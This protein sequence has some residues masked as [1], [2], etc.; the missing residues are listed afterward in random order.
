MLM[1]AQNEVF[2]EQFRLG[3]IVR[4]EPLMASMVLQ[5]RVQASLS[6]TVPSRASTAGVP[7]VKPQVRRKPFKLPD[8]MLVLPLR[9][10]F[11][12][13]PGGTALR[14]DGHLPS[15]AMTSK[16]TNL[17]VSSPA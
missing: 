16:Q 11:I 4:V 9:E 15:Q 2:E 3:K 1:L 14:A 7:K 8:P 13:L 5:G 6:A 17:R 10:V 12:L